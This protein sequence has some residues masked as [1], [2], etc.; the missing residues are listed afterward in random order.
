[1]LVGL[2]ARWCAALLTLTACASTAADRPLQVRPGQDRTTTQ[3]ELKAGA[4]CRDP[5][6]ARARTERYARCDR[7]G[8]DAGTSWAVVQYDGPHAGAVAEQ[9]SRWERFP[10]EL[11]AERRWNDLLEQ[12]A[13]IAPPSAVARRQI[14]DR[15]P[16][17]V[18]T[19]AWAAFSLGADGLVGVYLLS[20][21]SPDG[22][23]VLERI[24]WTQAR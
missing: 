3:A 10:T 4:Y 2:D 22:P 18:G 7:P 20:A 1:V 24:T 8:F 13:R 11:L 6:Q 16:P 17:P 9:V 15:T 14:A 5:D 21:S 23:G 12:R 19:T